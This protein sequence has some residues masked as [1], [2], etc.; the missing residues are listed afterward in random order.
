VSI[1]LDQ[2]K[3]ILDEIE[4]NE[5]AIKEA[6]ELLGT[7]IKTAGVSDLINDPKFQNI[8]NLLTPFTVVYKVNQVLRL[9]QEL[10]KEQ[11]S[12]PQIDP[13]TGYKKYI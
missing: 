4:L 5:P 7:I 2:A 8:V 3:T 10:A 11:K 12:V 6:Q 9:L 1:F 13:S